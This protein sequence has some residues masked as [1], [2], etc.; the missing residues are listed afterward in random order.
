MNNFF[1][2]F[3]CNFL[4][5]FLH[6]FLHNFLSQ[7]FITISCTIFWTIS[8]DFF[9]LF[10]NFCTIFFQKD[11]EGNCAKKL[12]KNCGKNHEENCAKNCAKINL[13]MLLLHYPR[14]SL[15][16]LK[17]WL[18]AS[19]GIRDHEMYFQATIQGIIKI[20][21]KFDSEKNWKKF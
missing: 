17:Q 16:D 18:S 19:S 21:E 10:C 1:H 12:F 20:L 11:S 4:H 5:I 2:D 8:S 6:Y 9:S 3:L 7:F 14:L 15:Y 13:K